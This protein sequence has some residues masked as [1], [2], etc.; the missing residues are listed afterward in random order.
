M[1]SLLK[2]KYK[3]IPSDN[4]GLKEEEF[5]NKASYHTSY[6][7]NKENIT[8]FLIRMPKSMKQELKKLSYVTE[9]NMNQICLDAIDLHIKTFNKNE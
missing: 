7:T 5:I 4:K 3:K 9:N 1:N 6:D 2:K 8:S